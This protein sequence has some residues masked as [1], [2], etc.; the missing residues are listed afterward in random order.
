MKYIKKT[1]TILLF[2]CFVIPSCGTSQIVNEEKRIESLERMDNW[3]WNYHTEMLMYVDNESSIVRVFDGEGRITKTDVMTIETNHTVKT[4]SLDLIRREK[5]PY[6]SYS[7]EEYIEE[8]YIS[9]GDTYNIDYQKNTLT[10]T[11]KGDLYKAYVIQD[12]NSGKYK[13]SAYTISSDGSVVTRQE[14]TLLSDDE[15]SCTIKY[16]ISRNQNFFKE[17][18]SKPN[19]IK[20]DIYSLDHPKADFYFA[21]SGVMMTA[22][23]INSVKLTFSKNA[24]LKIDY[25]NNEG[26]EVNVQISKIGSTIMEKPPVNNA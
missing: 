13:Y 11:G 15:L 20:D 23:Q 19:I 17:V 21:D 7:L 2:G 1:I 6:T 24:L 5:E 4:Y 14:P 26:R 22:H 25:A 12:G 3:T 8:Y 9:S 16:Y 18:V 10:V